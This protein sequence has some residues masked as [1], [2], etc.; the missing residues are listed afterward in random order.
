[1]SVYVYHQG[2]RLSHAVGCEFTI[3]LYICLPVC[4][5]VCLS[6]CLYVCLSNVS[7]CIIRES[8]SVM[9][10]AV[11]SQSVCTYVY[12]SACLSVYICM[13]VGQSVCLS[14]CLYVCLSNVSMCIIRVSV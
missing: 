13:S 8:V 10:L 14:V 3:C 6:V 5:S 7:M 12:L 2:E 1:M 4:L 9:P 11:S